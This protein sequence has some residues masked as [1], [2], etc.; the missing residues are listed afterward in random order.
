MITRNIAP[1][2]QHLARQ[3]PVVTVTGPRQSGKTT[4][5]KYL[6]PDKHYVT[7]E[8]P[9]VRRHATNDP[10]GFLVDFAQGAIFDEVQRAPELPSYLQGMVDADPQ[11]GRFIL[12]GSQQFELMT[13]VSQS[14]AGRTGVLRLLRSATIL[15]Y[16][17]TK[18]LPGVL[19]C[20]VCYP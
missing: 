1:I 10:R 19:A 4:L 5:V 3:Y 17:Q 18:R 9:D 6:F 20:C 14:L 11:P 7:L 15:Q 13:Q 8:D 16:K 12:T 2:L